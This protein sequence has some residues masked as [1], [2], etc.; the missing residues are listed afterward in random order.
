MTT[1]SASNPASAGTSPTLP[2]P[3][4]PTATPPPS[5]PD[6]AKPMIAV[7]GDVSVDWLTYTQPRSS[8]D[9]NTGCHP[10]RSWHHYDYCS[11]HAVPG[12][13]W[14]V[15]KTVRG[16]L[17]NTLSYVTVV[18]LNPDKNLKPDKSD[19]HT[20]FSLHFR[21]NTEAFFSVTLN[22][23]VPAHLG[24]DLEQGSY[25][26]RLPKG[27]RVEMK[28]NR[29]R[30]SIVNTP[31]RRYRP[32]LLTRRWEI[33][34][35]LLELPEHTL[36]DQFFAYAESSGH[37]I[38][39]FPF[40]DVNKPRLSTEL[41]GCLAFPQLSAE[42]QSSA[43][44]ITTGSSPPPFAVTDLSI[45]NHLGQMV[46]TTLTSDELPPGGTPH[47]APTRD[48]IGTELIELG[49]H[50]DFISFLTLKN[51]NM[52]TRKKDLI[53]S[54]SAL[55]LRKQSPHG[56]LPAEF[57]KSQVYR[58]V[59]V[60]GIA[61]P[62]HGHPEILKHYPDEKN[63]GVQRWRSSQNKILV[64]DDEGFGFS[65][66]PAAAWSP[67]MNEREPRGHRLVFIKSSRYSPALSS[68]PGSLTKYLS[69]PASDPL[70]Y[71]TVLVITSD[72]LRHGARSSAGLALSRGLS[73]DLIAEELWRAVQA[74]FFSNFP[75]CSNI[76]IQFGMNAVAL[77]QR[78]KGNV[79]TVTLV[80]DPYKADGEYA[81]REVLGEVMG[82]TT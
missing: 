45:D 55:E 57:G 73:W 62:R 5:D 7:V 82:S 6:P 18:D 35:S 33:E 4:V 69:E 1:S 36:V 12:G 29:A 53:Q 32:N 43:E 46:L 50:Y 74:G 3:P 34:D 77:V 15:A 10:L 17:H 56:Q 54:F 20:P 78:T 70:K 9:R 41:Y 51:E 26:I 37:R 48:G 52:Y 76:V 59:K 28:C 63:A 49:G 68:P 19:P 30:V 16:A 80:Y 25:F 40:N 42:F 67:W 39:F 14:Y 2:L 47:E 8:H 65:T 79:E 24:M 22:A 21:V 72:G 75:Y 66:S 31:T 60:L 11:F 58:R 64:V 61:G 23:R 44:R 13:S 27:T 81:D 38:E 71:R